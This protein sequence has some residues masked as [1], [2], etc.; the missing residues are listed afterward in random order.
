LHQEVLMVIHTRRHT[1]DALQPFTPWLHAIARHKFLDCL[2][3]S[4]LAIKDVPV[5][6]AQDLTAE[7]DM[8]AVETGLDLERLM[9]L[10]SHKA[11]L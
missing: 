8:T 1:Y 9:S 5:E 11:R 7:S 6:G 3:R 4:K 10:V 2:R